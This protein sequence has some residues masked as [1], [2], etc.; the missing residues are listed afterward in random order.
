MKMNL[1]IRLLPVICVIFGMLPGVPVLAQ[2]Q[3]GSG[4]SV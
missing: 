2:E 3:A 1:L 4:E